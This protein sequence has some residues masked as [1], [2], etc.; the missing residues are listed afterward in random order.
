MSKTCTYPSCNRGTRTHELCLYHRPRK[1]IKGGGRPK[2]RGKEYYRWAEFRE[3][4]AI[5]YLDDKFGHQCSCCG[6]GGKLDVD[7]IETRGAHPEMKYDLANLR[8]LC[9]TCHIARTAGRECPHG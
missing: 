2:Q 9:R 6:A 4:I 1:A 7:H 3:E 5:P 8:W